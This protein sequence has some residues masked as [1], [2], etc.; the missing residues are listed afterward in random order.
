MTSN[1]FVH[2]IEVGFGYAVE[3]GDAALLNRDARDGI[4]GRGECGEAEF[5]VF[6]S[7][8]IEIDSGLVHEAKA[9]YRVTHFVDSQRRRAASAHATS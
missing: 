6:Y 4:V 7:K 8:A 9:T 5:Y 1:E 3:L 2:G